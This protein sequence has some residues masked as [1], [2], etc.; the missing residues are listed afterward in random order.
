MAKLLTKSRYLNGLQC[1]KLLWTST[2]EP[3]LLSEPDNTTQYL[4]DQGHAIGELAKKL[5]PEGL[6]VPY[7]SFMDNISM[8]KNLVKQREP[9]FEAGVMSGNIYSRIDIL[10]PVNEDEWD[11]IEVKGSTSVKE[12]NLHDV[13]FQKL[14]CE[15][16][17]LSIRN[18]H[19]AYVN[20]KYVKNGEINPNELFV[21]E[22]ISAKVEEVSE[23]IHERIQSMFDFI[24][25]KTCPELGIGKHC[26][27]PYECMLKETCWDF[28]PKDN[29]F[30]LRGGKTKQFSLYDKGILYIKDIPDSERLSRQ[31]QIQKECVITGD[32][33]IEKDEIRQFLDKL[34]YPLY[35]LDFE[36]IGPAI[37]IY[38]GTRPYQDVP[39]QF[40][41]HIVGSDKSE[42]VHHAFL[43]DGKEDPRF[44]LLKELHELL[45]SEG[46]IVA[47]N[48][49]F[50]EGVLRDLVEFLPEY[51]DW[52]E[53]I[54]I[55][56]VDLLTPFS[57][58]HYY[59]AYQKD[60]ASLKRVLPAITGRSY[61]EMGIGAGM[62]ASIAYLRIAY[63]EV[64][65]EEIST[66]RS[67][68]LK[69][70]QLDT[71]GM[72]WIVEKLRELVH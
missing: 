6:N 29:V 56:I 19:L 28:L 2:N 69:Y 17:G 46:S 66:I 61:E 25:A 60:T 18:C 41:L 58:F 70:C 1:P 32:T 51:K 13:S 49:G 16:A 22:D 43:A 45:G 64:S 62:D 8:T 40:S 38:D 24:S 50:E 20:N 5:F 10:N 55:R 3:A 11:I 44:Q 37:P 39:F 31:Q 21:I 36:T 23:N 72:I 54:D 30:D 34:E 33:H 65:E 14:C 42:P 7:D 59:N 63:G 52:F 15:N 9:L 27:A 68:L 12:I 53:G 57:N 26:L 67:D 71:E 35:F 47:Y 4:F 48:S